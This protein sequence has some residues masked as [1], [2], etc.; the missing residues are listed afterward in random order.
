MTEQATTT[1]SEAAPPAGAAPQATG[2]GAHNQPAAPA[3]GPSADA[4]APAAETVYDV[5]LP[6]GSRMNDT[7]LAMLVDLARTHEINPETTSLLVENANAIVTQV[8]ERAK[9][10]WISQV[11]GW[12]KEI[13]EDK[14]IGGDKYDAN[15][16][17]ARELLA[18]HWSA[19]FIAELNETGLG[20]HPDFLRGLVAL[21]KHTT[22][23][24]ATAPGGPATGPSFHKLFDKSPE[25]FASGT[26]E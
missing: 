12:N 4:P 14:D 15:M 16:Q 24:T 17:A 11:E 3:A 2:D 19:D 20:E 21:A 25:L 10:E 22:E 8:N 5:Q 9:Q 18:A 23:G 26:P 7:D 6:E 1:A 13:R